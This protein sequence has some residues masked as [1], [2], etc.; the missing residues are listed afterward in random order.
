MCASSFFYVIEMEVCENCEYYSNTV[1]CDKIYGI[2][3]DVGSTS[4]Q[5][6]LEFDFIDAS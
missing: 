5:Q 2:K 1:L 6:I 4:R 3:F